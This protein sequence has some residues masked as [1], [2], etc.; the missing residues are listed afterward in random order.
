M[1][2]YP[3]R[4]VSRAAVWSRRLASFSLVLFLTAAIGHRLV[5]LES[6]GFLAVLAAVAALAVVALL[7]AAY[8]FSRLWSYGDAGG[9]NLAVAFLVASVVLA[10]FA[11]SLY[12]GFVY[13]RLTDI[14]T[15]LDD[16]P[17][18]SV[19]AK[20]RRADMNAILPFTPEKK[21]LQLDKYPLVT[22][23]RYEMPFGRVIEAV[24][25]IV[26]ARSWQVV[27]PRQTAAEEAETTIE[28]V[29]RTTLLAFPV[30]IAIRLTDEETST[31]VDMRSA[32]RYGSHDFGDNAARIAAFL[33]ELD[34]E[35]SA[36]AG[37]LPAEGEGEPAE[38]EPPTPEPRPQN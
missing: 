7:L 20:A 18:L 24:S 29:A 11:L 13:P 27:S 34:A 9:R 25:K 30:D 38:G 23:R 26:A 12:R 36:L 21:Q 3:E 37:V 10:P 35:V 16:P 31:Y 19:A 4:R 33:A 6:P 8:G 1:A 2:Y 28:A 14:S 5:L 32:S 17:K 22:G 15:D